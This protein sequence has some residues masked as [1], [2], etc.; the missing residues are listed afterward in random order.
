M[1]PLELVGQG[2]ELARHL[3]RGPVW[4]EPADR[5]EIPG[6]GTGRVEAEWHPELG[7]AGVGEAR[8]HDADDGRGKTVECDRAADHRLVGPEAPLPQRVAQHGHQA[9]IRAILLG[10]EATPEERPR[11]QHDE[12][13]VGHVR[14]GESLRLAR[15]GEVEARGGVRREAGECAALVAVH[16]HEGVCE[17]DLGQPLLGCGEPCTHQA[18]GLVVGQWAQEHR[19]HHAEE[20]RVGPDA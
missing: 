2:R 8:R 11:T 17:G 7:T 5:P 20:E 10:E 14:A 16:G 3:G 18:A 12:E 13:I 19:P 15:A 1:P 9:L 6:A 4:S